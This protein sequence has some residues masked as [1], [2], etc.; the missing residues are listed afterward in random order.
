MKTIAVTSGKG[1][2]GKTCLTANL[3][4]GLKKLGIRPMVFD[5]DLALANLEVAMGVRPEATLQHVVVEEKS[6][7][8]AVTEGPGGLRLI[9]GGS[10]VPMLMRAGPKKLSL[11]FDQLDELAETTDLLLFDTGAG[12]DTRNLAFLRRADEILLVTT[13]EPASVT[14]AYATLKTLFRY[15]KD[16]SVRVVVNMA[17]NESEGEAVFGVLRQIA[18]DFLKKE[19][20]YAGCVRRDPTV[21]KNARKRTLFLQSS[22]SSDASQ[23]VMKLAGVVE[24]F[25]QNRGELVA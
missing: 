24:Q 17:A 12:L 10:G 19:V 23:D 22:P 25:L 5:A 13:P 11:I 1:G 20:S 15:K 8:E 18:K 14:D 4:L 21:P 6:L 2:V 3:G 9:A 16:A 7:A